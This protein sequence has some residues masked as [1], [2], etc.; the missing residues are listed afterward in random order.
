M[1]L[2]SSF[3]F[4]HF[5]DMKILPFRGLANHTT[6]LLVIG[7]SSV[8][9]VSCSG[10]KSWDV[11]LS[12]GRQAVKAGDAATA[13]KCFEAAIKSA[14][15]KFGDNHGETATC[16]PDLAEMY[17][18]Q[19]EYR[20][21]A[22]VFKDLLPIYAKIEP[23]SPDDLRIQEEYKQVKHKIKKY[24]MEPGAGD[25]AAK[26]DGS[27]SDS[28]SK[29]SKDSKDA[30]DSKDSKDEIKATKTKSESSSDTNKKQAK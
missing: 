8:A 10:S 1:R 12:E 30:K 17:M 7:L 25:N 4:A 14:K 21:A 16:M 24:R 28:D 3:S 18:A 2:P 20:K 13:E 22:V 5:N 29:D 19:G 26:A 11:S 27:K 6:R 23:G 9:L 15:A